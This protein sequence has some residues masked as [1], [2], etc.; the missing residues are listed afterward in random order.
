MKLAFVSVE[1]GIVAIGFRKM[2]AV[3]RTMQPDAGV[4]Y[5]VPAQFFNPL[6]LILPNRVDKDIF[7]EKEIDDIAE[8][9]AL[10][11]MV[12]FSSMTAFSA[13]T[14]R[15]IAKIRR[16][17]RDAYIVW[18]GVHSIVYPEDAIQFADAI[19]VGEGEKDFKEFFT[20]FRDGLDFTMTKN[21]W[22]NIG[23]RIIKNGFSP[24]NTPQEMDSF[25]F[26]L[27]ADRELI[28][29]K[30]KRGFADCGLS[31]YLANNSLCYNTVWSIGCPNKCIYCSNSKFTENDKN[32]KILR[33]PSVEYI[34]AEVESVLEKHPHISTISF[35]DDSFMAIPYATLER[36]ASLWKERISKP[37]CVLGLIPSYVK[38]D[39]IDVLVNAG[40]IRVR[41]GIQSGSDRILKFYKRPNPAGVILNASSVLAEFKEHMLPPSYDI[42]LDNPI[43]ERDDVVATLEM[44]YEIHR[45]FTLNIFSLRVIP[46]TELARE[47]ERLNINV[48]D[49]KH[50]FLNVKPT[51]ANL[52]VYLLILFKPPKWMFRRLLGRVK[53][54][55]EKQCQYPV[56]MTIL[57]ILVY[58]KKAL[59][60]L[61]FLYFDAMLGKV[62]YILYKIGLIKYYQ[63]RNKR[64]VQ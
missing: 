58:A 44:L 32:Y 17:N 42:I 33:H 39:K 54:F 61:R 27:Y 31:D 22:F 30:N 53:P 1:N 36:F 57:R 9:L 45:P 47:F 4:Y 37:F 28:Y 29:R 49:I 19:C 3:A 8:H 6:N 62:G 64:Y 46:N 52:L 10:F 50:N 2:A 55:H 48:Q 38:R 13:L 59:V 15:I 63:R 25:P 40:M 41:M 12:C 60:Y 5:V 34:I 20:F 56:S 7:S 23:D 14:K 26:P 16:V 43:E 18:G 51:L 24:L 11:D 21:F 35:H